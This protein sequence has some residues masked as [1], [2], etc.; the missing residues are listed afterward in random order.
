M[1]P[2]KNFLISR[3]LVDLYIPKM[4]HL[5]LHLSGNLRVRVALCL[6][7]LLLQTVTVQAQTNSNYTFD[8]L[9][10]CGLDTVAISKLGPTDD[11]EPCVIAKVYPFQTT[12][13][14][15][16]QA[17][18][19]SMVQ[20]TPS[21]C[22]NHRDGSVTGVHVLNADNESRGVAIGFNQDHFVQFYFVS[23][24]AG[25]P[26]F[27]SEQEYD[28]RHDQILRSMITTLEAPYIVGSCSFASAVEKEPAQDLKA[29][30]LAQVG[31]SAFY[32]DTNPYL[33]GF[34]ISSDS[35]PLPNVQSLGFLAKEVQGGAP[36]IPVRVIYRTKSEFFYS[37]CKSAID[38]LVQDGFTDLV[39]ILYDH[40]ADHDNDGDINQFDDDFLI[41]LA[42]QA[43]PPGSDPDF[44]PALFVCTLS[45]HDTIVKRWIQNGCKP[46]STWVTA[47]TWGWADNNP[48][49]VPY[50]QGGGQWHGAFDY[51]DRYF[52]RGL[53]VLLHNEER[54]KY[55]GDYNQLVSYAIPVL[56]AQHLQ[57]AYR[58]QDTPRPLQD[59]ATDEGREILR[60]A[61]VVLN[62]DSIFGPIAFDDHQR[63]IG[64]G[65]AGTQW[66]PLNPDDSFVNALVSPFLQAQA[67]TVIPAS[68]ALPCQAG[69]FIN[70]TF[71]VQQGSVLAS[72]CEA[73]PA[74][75]FSQSESQDLECKPCPA[76]S[77]TEGMT[78]QTFCITEQD[79]LLSSGILAFG[80]IAVAITW[81]LSICFLTWLYLHRKD[82]IVRVSQ[83]EFMALICIGAMI[84]SSTIIALTFQAGSDEDTSQ[85]SA[86]CTA[87][88]FL[89]AIGW[90]LQYSSLSAKTFRLYK[91]VHSQQRMQ[92]VAISFCQMFRIIVFALAVDL[93]IVIAWTA[94]NPLVV[95]NLSTILSLL[96]C[97]QYYM[98]TY[99]NAFFSF[100]AFSMSEASQTEG[101]TMKQA[102]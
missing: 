95:S 76:G 77:S 84:S 21:N 18:I 78:G 54:Y 39:E 23:V 11:L 65:A 60:R 87:A 41:S 63:N 9:Q 70:D 88:P 85:A 33:F 36:S 20:V 57:A 59:F 27:L 58:V 14:N 91:V 73:C 62:V 81:T 86:G 53:D 50:Y 99:S 80:Y 55:M 92:R 42:D 90:V 47:A 5:H 22:G 6:F 49:I 16:S 75:F 74:D 46:V 2:E 3:P 35:Y 64:R 98:G 1:F 37:T 25:N 61:M 69:Q 29:I 24:I 52:N 56:Y 94:T 12:G 100:F 72:G 48:D 31:P 45:E 15:E 102:S 8:D 30:L 13:L 7:L 83:I 32:T 40:A 10:P 89:Y 4:L 19:I 82:P 66:L 97:R 17:S 93:I 71:R 51:S 34:H 43:C 26:A 79:N 28:R 96:C 101:L 44:H 38:R 67:N 68:S